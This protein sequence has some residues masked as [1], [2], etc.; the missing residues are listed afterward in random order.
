MNRI[1]EYLITHMCQIYLDHLE[2]N[3]IIVVDQL[4]EEIIDEIS[5]EFN[6]DLE[7]NND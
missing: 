3:G 2:I 6:L 1:K 5:R 7:E 4:M